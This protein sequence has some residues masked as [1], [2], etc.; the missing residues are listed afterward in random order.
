MPIPYV[1]IKWVI[2]MWLVK[3]LHHMVRKLPI[4]GH[5]AS[6][7]KGIEEKVSALIGVSWNPW[8]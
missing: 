6:V 8:A 5:K 3:K 1:F 4:L 2:Y 7:L